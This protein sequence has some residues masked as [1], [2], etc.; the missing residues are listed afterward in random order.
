MSDTWHDSLNP[1]RGCLHCAEGD[2]CSHYL[3][4]ETRP[5]QDCIDD[6]L[7]AAE[8]IAAGYGANGEDT[9]SLHD[10][11]DDDHARRPFPL[12]YYREES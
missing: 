1:R 9:G 5:C 11:S 4:T 3:C 6:A 12:S 2:P 10:Y 8:N 7:T